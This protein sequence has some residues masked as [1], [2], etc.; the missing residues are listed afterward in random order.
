M[1]S[2]MLRLGKKRLFVGAFTPLRVDLDPAG[3]FTLDD[4]EFRVPSG[5][6]GGVVSLAREPRFTADRPVLMLLA[7]HKPGAHMIEAVERT[8]STVVGET[9]FRIS[10]TWRGA[11][12]GPPLWF[13]GNP[14]QREPGRPSGGQ[15]LRGRPGRPTEHRHRPPLGTRRVAILFVDTSS[16]RYTTD[17]ATM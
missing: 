10:G 15:R 4:L 5:L 8:S 12:T 7:G 17:A 6:A 14:V 3:G 2:V 11:K 1:A 16:Q 9:R 13:S